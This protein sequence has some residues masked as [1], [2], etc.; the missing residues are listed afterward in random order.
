MHACSLHVAELLLHGLRV[1]ERI[2]VVRLNVLRAVLNVEVDVVDGLLVDHAPSG[3][4]LRGGDQLL[5]RQLDVPQVHRALR[6]GAQVG[7]ARLGTDVVLLVLAL[8]YQVFLKAARAVHLV[9][10]HRIVREV[11]AL[12][13][14]VEPD[15]RRAVQVLLVL[16]H[17]V[18]QVAAATLKDLLLVRRGAVLSEVNHVR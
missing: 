16:L 10:V 1:V 14:R 6:A 9:V 5:V 4:V 8:V 3:V 17:D 12:V 7:G 11:H 15:A 18:D 2:V 13:N